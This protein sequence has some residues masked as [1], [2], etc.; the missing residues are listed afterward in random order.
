VP[1]ENLND[2]AGVR[3]YRRL[4]KQP[5]A[6]VRAYY[7]ALTAEFATPG[8]E[9]DRVENRGICTTAGCG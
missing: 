1:S 7:E 2:P 4:G 3:A 8:A 5:I 6:Q 9:V